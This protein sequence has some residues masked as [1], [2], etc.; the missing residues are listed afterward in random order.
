M[1]EDKFFTVTSQLLQL[2]TREARQYQA[3]YPQVITF[4]EWNFKKYLSKQK[5]SPRKKKKLM[6]WQRI[7]NLMTKHPVSGILNASCGNIRELIEYMEA[8]FRKKDLSRKVLLNFD[9]VPAI[10]EH[11]DH[12]LENR[13]WNYQQLGPFQQAWSHPTIDDFIVVNAIGDANALLSIP[14]F[15]QISEQLKHWGLLWLDGIGNVLPH[16]IQE[17]TIKFSKNWLHHFEFLKILPN[18]KWS[19][20]TWLYLSEDGQ[21]LVTKLKFY[22]KVLWKASPSLFH[23]CSLLIL[24]EAHDKR[25]Q[26]LLDLIPFNSLDERTFLDIQKKLRLR[27]PLSSI[28][29]QV[30]DERGELTYGAFFLNPRY[31]AR[32][33][34]RRNFSMEWHID[35]TVYP[36]V[37]GPID[38]RHF[39]KSFYLETIS[40][41]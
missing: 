33:L 38:E 14:N 8:H 36:S 30:H 16:K 39:I 32:W 7:R 27:K 34:R 19:H 31:L 29:V 12:V 13:G 40:S 15:S 2:L 21:T 5:F 17:A 11:A 18:F 9:V 28:L 41:R 3:V 20:V 22:K 35:E 37:K 23:H 4:W 24:P 10:V 6:K 1:D 26:I 25:P